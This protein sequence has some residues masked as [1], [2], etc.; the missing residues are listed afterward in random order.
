MRAS[1]D[2]AGPGTVF[3]LYSGVNP[4]PSIVGRLRNASPSDRLWVAGVEEASVMEAPAASCP[5]GCG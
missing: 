1:A 3:E 5:S 4:R 2:A